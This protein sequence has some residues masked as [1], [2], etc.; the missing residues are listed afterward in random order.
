MCYISMYEL[1]SYIY[2]LVTLFIS[3]TATPGWATPA[4]A[5]FLVLPGRPKKFSVDPR[6]TSEDEFFN[7]FAMLIFFFSCNVHL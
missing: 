4:V 5:M 1:Y 7:N 6:C 3:S 2:N